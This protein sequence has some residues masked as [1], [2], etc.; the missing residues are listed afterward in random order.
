ME[1]GAAPAISWVSRSLDCGPVT[2]ALPWPW[3]WPGQDPAP[4][5]RT[6]GPHGEPW[7]ASSSWLPSSWPEQ[8]LS[9][10]RAGMEKATQEERGEEKR[11]GS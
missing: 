6:L 7:A 4:G 1:H 2:A 11:A 5:L 3:L 9:Q 8:Q 10:E